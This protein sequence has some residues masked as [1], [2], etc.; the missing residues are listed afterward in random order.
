MQGYSAS[1]GELFS[2]WTRFKS[3]TQEK[4]ASLVKMAEPFARTMKM[5]QFIPLLTK[6]EIDMSLVSE[7]ESIMEKMAVQ[8]ILSFINMMLPKDNERKENPFLAVFAPTSYPME[9]ASLKSKSEAQLAEAVVQKWQELA[10]GTTLKLQHFPYICILKLSHLIYNEETLNELAQLI[11]IGMMLYEAHKFD[12]LLA[13][14]NEH[15]TSSASLGFQATCAFAIHYIYSRLG[16]NESNTVKKAE[17]KNKASQVV[18]SVI[19]ELKKNSA[20]VECIMLLGMCA[21]FHTFLS[22]YNDCLQLFNSAMQYYE[23]I[24]CDIMFD[25]PIDYKCTFLALLYHLRMA[26]IANSLSEYENVAKHKAGA[27]KLEAILANHDYKLTNEY[28]TVVYAVQDELES[29]AHMLGDLQDNQIDKCKSSSAA[30]CR[31]QS[32]IFEAN[33]CLRFNENRQALIYLIEAIDDQIINLNFPHTRLLSLESMQSYFF[34]KRNYSMCTWI[35]KQLLQVS[36]MHNYWQASVFAQATNG[37][38]AALTD[39]SQNSIQIHEQVL[40]LAAANIKENAGSEHLRNALLDQLHFCFSNVIH[41]YLE[42]GQKIKALEALNQATYYSLHHSF[43]TMTAKEIKQCAVTTKSSIIYLYLNDVTLHYWIVDKNGVKYSNTDC[44]FNNLRTLIQLV[45]KEDLFSTPKNDLEQCFVD[46]YNILFVQTGLVTSIEPNASIVFVP[47][48]SLISIPFGCLCIKKGHPLI[49]D[50]DVS[51][52]LD[53]SQK[54]EKHNSKPNCNDALVFS[55]FSE[56]DAEYAA[57]FDMQTLK[58]DAIPALVDQ[59][60][61]QKY[62]VSHLKHEMATKVNLQTALSKKYLLFHLSSHATDLNELN[63]K[64]K[65][66]FRY[67][68]VLY[69][70][71]G[72]IAAEQVAAGEQFPK[73]QCDYAVLY[74]CKTAQGTTSSKTVSGIGI[75]RAFSR[76][77]C[78]TVIANR[79]LAVDSV[80]SFGQCNAQFLHQFYHYLLQ[81]HLTPSMAIRKAMLDSDKTD[82]AMWNLMIRYMA[83]SMVVFGAN[84]AIL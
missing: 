1:K 12:E 23:D 4:Q 20:H 76:A 83:G 13:L 80:P 6:S 71:D 27:A 42:T 52:C 78:S 3:M 46:L 55:A 77:G 15:L 74:A 19:A 36:Q 82:N 22:E 53:L 51:I 61:A 54:M 63:Q 8:P 21:E 40:H 39:S 7:L 9:N 24:Y 57:I 68:G 16:N 81:C 84:N 11:S 59:L 18:E 64:E 72:V 25:E 62:N 26:T 43:C 10:S 32:R 45:N 60:R 79:Y 41:L 58:N 70:H 67:H 2:I 28:K 48:S 34:E 69:T 33:K 29:L 14:L 56:A 47:Y 17:Y 5:N 31:I 35:N 65:S 49:M 30:L 66:P 73:V 44:S 38:L 50:H 37:V 75:H